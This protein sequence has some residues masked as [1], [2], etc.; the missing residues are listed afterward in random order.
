MSR[1]FLTSFATSDWNVSRERIS[2]QSDE[3][4]KTA[5]VFSGRFLFD[6]SALSGEY[7]DRFKP[8][9]GMHGYGLYSWK[10]FVCMHALENVNDGDFVLYIDG[11]CSLPSDRAAEFKSRITHHMDMVAK[12]GIRMGFGVFGNS[13]MNIRIIRKSI[14]RDFHLIDVREFLYDYPH[15]EANGIL[16]Q[17]DPRSSEFINGWSRYIRDRFETSIM[18]DYD[19]KS[20]QYK[21]YIHNC[22]DQAV[23][24]CM[25]Y[26]LRKYN[27]N[28]DQHHSMGNFFRDFNI[29]TRIRK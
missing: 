8:F 10:P 24:Q 11:G 28:K 14:L 5:N 17:K 7:M 21:E 15:F 16:M 19:D 12:S 9:L 27:R 2:A 22:G 20:G 6:E 25:L 1:L 29:I 3:M 4:N 26:K 18:S 13:K 23:L